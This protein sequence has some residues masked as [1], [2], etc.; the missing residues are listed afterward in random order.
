MG[1]KRRTFVAGILAALL[2]VL[3]G[4]WLAMPLRRDEPP[5]GAVVYIFNDEIYVGPELSI[6]QL[7]QS[8]SMRYDDALATYVPALGSDF[9]VESIGPRAVYFFAIM[10]DESSD[11]QLLQW[12]KYDEK[13]AHKSR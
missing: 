11:W 4:I 1:F 2:L 6:D 12:A 10:S 7:K 13:L 3:V 8:Q 5:N 9:S